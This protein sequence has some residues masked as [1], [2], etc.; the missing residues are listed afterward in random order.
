MRR[1]FVRDNIETRF[2]FKGEVDEVSIRDRHNVSTDSLLD[3]DVDCIMPKY[4][5][6]LFDNDSFKFAFAGVSV[7]LI[8]R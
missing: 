6:V 1:H 4:L 5:F 8:D 2:I 7:V 3:V